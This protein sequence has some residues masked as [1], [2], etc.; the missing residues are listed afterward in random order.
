MGQE[1]SLV[2]MGG[3]S[4]LEGREFK[5]Q[6]CTLDG[7][8][9]TH[10]FIVK[11]VMFVWKDGNKLKEAGDCPFKKP[12]LGLVVSFS[13]TRFGEIL[14]HYLRGYFVLGKFFNL[15]G[16][17]F[18]I[19]GK[20]PSLLLAQYWRDNLPSGHTGELV[21]SIRNW[22]RHGRSLL[23]SALLATLYSGYLWT[24]LS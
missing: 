2:V 4:S 6:D 23:K 24:T 13:L 9:F 18:R 8:F 17:N 7:H 12:L 5:S 1:P 11:I 16:Y 20:F 10:I 3:D 22:A 14:P 21:P 15:I 19:L